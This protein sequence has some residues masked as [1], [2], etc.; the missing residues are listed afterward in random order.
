[1]FEKILNDS[2]AST[3][4]K[5]VQYLIGSILIVVLAVLILSSWGVAIPEFVSGVVLMGYFNILR[6]AAASYYKSRDEIQAAKIETEKV[7]AAKEPCTSN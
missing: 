6:D 5:I 7:V 4:F 1:M 2:E 3:R